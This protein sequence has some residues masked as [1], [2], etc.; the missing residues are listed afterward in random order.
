VEEV[1]TVLDEGDADRVR[2]VRAYER[3]HKNR[4]GVIDAADRELV[5]A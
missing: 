2:R 3:S 4:S 5:K 1:R